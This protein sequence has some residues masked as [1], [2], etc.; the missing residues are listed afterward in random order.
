MAM[1]LTTIIETSA[2]TPKQPVEIYPI[3][4]VAVADASQGIICSTS[5]A[6]CFR[7]VWWPSG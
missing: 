1:C 3:P 7:G 6:Q 4:M 2:I 5:V